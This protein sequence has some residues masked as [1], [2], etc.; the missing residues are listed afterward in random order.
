MCN[1]IPTKG[2]VDPGSG[3]TNSTGFDTVQT[4]Q[5]CNICAD[6]GVTNIGP[7]DYLLLDLMWNPTFCNA[8]E[9]GHD[10]TLTHMPSMRC[11][12]SLSERLS[13]HGLWPSWLKTFGTC[14]NATGSNKPLD[15]HEVTNEWDNSLRLR[16][17]EDW[18]DPVLYNG[19]FNEDNGCQICYVQNHEW[20]KHG[21]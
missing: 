7:Y 16:M 1:D 6:G 17:L 12:P 15:P 9:D 11:S 5:C 10:F 18:Y 2:Y 19:R 20:Q 4:D 14:C 8:L 13:I 3:F 21:A